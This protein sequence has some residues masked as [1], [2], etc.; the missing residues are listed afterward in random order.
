MNKLKVFYLRGLPASGKSTHSKKILGQEVN[1]VRVNKDN[2]RDMLAN[3]SKDLT[4]TF[5]KQSLSDMFTMSQNKTKA[6]YLVQEVQDALAKEFVGKNLEKLFKAQRA[7]SFGPKEKFVIQVQSIILKCFVENSKDIIVDDTNYNTQHFSRIKDI[8]KGYIFKFIDMHEDFGITVEECIKRNKNRDK[9]VPD[10]AIYSMAKK[11]NVGRADGSPKI[12]A[13]VSDNDYIICDLDG[14]LCDIDHRLRFIHNTDKKDWDGFFDAMG[15]DSL[16]PVTKQLIDLTYPNHSVVIVT[17]RPEKYRDM[18]TT[19]LKDND[20][21]Y[22]A[23]YMRRD[24]DRRPDTIVKQE[25]LDLYLDKDK[26]EMVI[27][28]RPVVIRQWRSNGLKVIDVG[29]GKEF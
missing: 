18:T 21:R 14:T 7:K 11:Y 9:R 12:E 10:I 8:C 16:R 28:D 25:I 1:T 2:I 15:K 27:D 3:K 13:F 19:W 5:D 20:V 29:D 4:E 23:I 6:T 17:G 24:G 22:D 26:V